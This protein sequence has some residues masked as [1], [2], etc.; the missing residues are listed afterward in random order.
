MGMMT[1]PKDRDDVTIA[2]ENAISKK[3]FSS[4]GAGNYMFMGKKD[5]KDLFKNINTREYIE[6]PSFSGF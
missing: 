3:A 6:I 4:S 2:F 1:G 5:G